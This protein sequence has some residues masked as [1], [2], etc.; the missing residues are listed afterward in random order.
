MRTTLKSFLVLILFS[1]HV[2]AGGDNDTHGARS[3]GLGGASLIYQDVWSAFNN[4]AGLAQLKKISAGIFNESRFLLNETSTKGLAVAVPT[5]NSG[6]FGASMNYFGYS[7][8]NEKK[9]GLAYAKAFGKNISAGIQLDYLNSEF[10]ENYGSKSIFTVELGFQANL[11]DK[12]RVG[13]HVYNPQKAKLADYNDEH[14]PAI[15][16]IGAGYLF[17]DKVTWTLEAEKDLDASGTIKS[18]IEYRIADPLYLRC[19]INSN[20]VKSAFGIGI[21]LGDFQLDLAADYHQVL[22]FTPQ[23]SLTY[24]PK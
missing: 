23:A 19:G 10:A 15:M 16:K 21:L 17:S 7:L 9:F 22:G 4:Q 5:T 14:T 2:L 1:S 20:P 6:V 24:C 3:G 8:Y 11:S 18:G 12:I 13:F